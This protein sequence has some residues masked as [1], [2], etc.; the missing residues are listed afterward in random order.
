MQMIYRKMF[1]FPMFVC[2][3]GKCS[4][5]YFTLCVWGN[6]KQINRKYPHPQPPEST[7]N[8][9]HCQPATQTHPATPQP[10]PQPTQT[11]PAT[12]QNNHPVTHKSQQPPPQ[13]P[14][15]PVLKNPQIATTK[16]NKLQQTT[17]T[18]THITGDR[19][20]KTHKP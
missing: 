9:P 3:L 4:R 6:V 17:T 20:L 11:H 7:K 12:H 10:T 13:K 19:C 5:K 2:T 18:K 1:V 16:S 15:S 8:D 14:T